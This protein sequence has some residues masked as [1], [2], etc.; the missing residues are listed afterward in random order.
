MKRY[1]YTLLILL[2]MFS[3]LSA[4]RL[5]R[6][7]D[8]Q[9][10]AFV[11]TNFTGAK[12]IH[13]Y[14]ADDLRL[15]RGSE[16]LNNAV[17]TEN[18]NGIQLTI[19]LHI[20]SLN[21]IPGDGLN[22]YFY[23]N[24]GTG[25]SQNRREL[26][27]DTA[28][29]L[30][31]DLHDDD[32]TQ[33]RVQYDVTGW[34]YKT[35][36]HIVARYD[37]N[38]DEIEL[39]TDGVSRDATPDNALSSD[40]I[41]AVGTTTQIGADSS[42]ANQANAKFVIQVFS[43]S[44][45][46]AE[47][48][49]DYD[50]GDFTTPVSDPDS[51]LAMECVFGTEDTGIIYWPSGKTVSAS[52]NSATETT[53][54]TADGADTAFKD[55]DRLSLR[56]GTGFGV[57]PV[58]DGDP[59]SGT[60]VDVD[61]GAGALVTDAEK[62]GVHANL[63]GTS[64]SF[65]A[66]DA[67]FP[68]AGI[69]GATDFTAQAHINI[70]DVTGS[71][72][73]I[74]KWDAA[75]LMWLF[76]IV[77]DELEMRISVDGAAQTGAISTIANIQP[78]TWIHVAGVYDA[79]AGT[80]DFYV[81][82]NFLEQVGGLANSIA[83]KTPNLLIGG[84]SSFF[85]QGGIRNISLFND[86]RTAAEILTSATTPLEDLSLAGNII[87]QWYFT[88]GPTATVIDNNEG[89]AGGDLVLNGGDTTDYSTHS[90]TTEAFLTR[91]LW[92][93]GNQESGGIAPGIVGSNSVV[94]KDALIRF[95]DD[96]S[97]KHVWTAANDNDEDQ[98]FDF[99]S[100]SGVDHSVGFEAKITA[101]DA[102]S[103]I[104]LDIDGS[105]TPIVSRRI[106]G[107]DDRDNVWIGGNLDFNGTSDYVNV[108]DDNTLD[109]LLTFEAW[110]K[111]AGVGTDNQRHIIITK[112]VSDRFGLVIVRI[113]GD[114]EI[115]F[116]LQD[117]LNILRIADW[118]I[119]SDA[120]GRWLHILGKSNLAVSNRPELFIDGVFVDS[121]GGLNDTLGFGTQ[122]TGEPVRI[123]GGL[124]TRYTDCEIAIA[125]AYSIAVSDADILWLSRNPGATKA[126]IIAATAII[127]GDIEL[128]L[129][130]EGDV[131]TDQSG[132]GNDGV[133]TGTTAI[134]EWGHKKMSFE[135]D[136][137]A[138]TGKVRI[139]RAG[140]GANSAT[141]YVDEGEVLEQLVTQ[142]GCE[143]ADGNTLP[144]GWSDTGS[145]DADETQTDTADFHSG[146]SSILL[147]NCDADEGVTQDVTVVVDQ[148]YTFS[149]WEKNNSQDI[150][151][152][153]SV[154]ATKTIDATGDNTW[155]NHRY[156]FK[157]ATTTLTIKFTSG[158]AN[159]SSWIDDVTVTRLDTRANTV[160]KT[161]GFYPRRN[162]LNP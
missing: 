119:P 80:V 133:K 15:P 47:V 77:N 145:P 85:F 109:A 59:A 143:A 41:G 106:S 112:H 72:F 42:Q 136:Q 102:D 154:A 25:V 52:S 91:N 150:N 104:D 99:T 100:A 130:F 29:L 8:F 73:L 35:E 114:N 40:T 105:A 69:T 51:I 23:D 28:G 82:G 46:D 30:I 152:V 17:V 157:A 153:L 74:G 95:A 19:L 81:N 86:I 9:Y 138:I 110:V 161:P 140:A 121:G 159:Q 160:T 21:F 78:N 89:T 115:E 54:T 117:S 12:G 49:A 7:G 126:E 94:T 70:P 53:L 90:R 5:R 67:N 147:N 6:Q 118:N 43:R 4:Q 124:A 33:H 88:D 44:W 128:Y 93:D 22:H 101:K 134:N 64:H 16:S 3:P 132:N 27:I 139:T 56:D 156:T 83:D 98:L 116:R 148:Y 142:P 1:I 97:E 26:Y 137:A 151:A 66:T 36:Y 37:L 55:G 131:V 125:R 61:D 2:L 92:V 45:L 144:T 38:A 20:K 63:N 60:S 122:M 32:S 39:Y 129:N 58:S 107:P 75:K 13:E 31:F 127:A 108:P 50:L 68:A 11:A 34:S 146:L 103:S 48:T 158:S 162:P 57:S 87:G 79:S 71:K 24:Q 141:V 84:F 113:V 155:T 111:F 10:D 76:W 18:D 135:A 96:Q 149:F 120:Y 62:V 123:G 14:Y 65:I